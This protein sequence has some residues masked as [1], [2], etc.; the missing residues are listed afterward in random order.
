MFGRVIRY[1]LYGSV[2]VGSGAIVYS[3]D[4]AITR[5]SRAAITAIDIGRTYKSMLYSKEWDKTSKEYIELK[6]QAHQIGAEKL[7]K[8]C[9][10]NKGVYIKVGQHIGALDYL[11]PSEYVM[12]MRVLHKDAPQNTLDELYKVI[13]EDLKKD[14]EELFDEFETEPLGTA[15]LAQVHKAKLKDGT[16]V[17]VKVQHF[18]LDK[19]I[20]TDMKCMEVIINVMSKV[21]PE[22]QMQW[23]VDETKKNIQKEIDFIQEGQNAERVADMFKNYSWLKVPKIYWDY[24]TKRVLVMEYCHGGQVNDIEYVKNHKI[25]PFDLCRKIGD[26]FS[27]MIFVE[28]FLHSDP[29][30]GNIL[31]RKEPGDKHVTVTLLDHGLY[32]NL[33]EKFRYHYSKLWLSIISRDKEEMS[34]HAEQLGI[35]KELYILFACMVTG[36]PWE[37]ILKGIDRTKPTSSEK[38]QFQ[39]ELPHFL[40]YVT[41]CLETVDRQA[42]LVLKTNDL[43]RSIEHALGTR[44]HMV[45]FQVM[46]KCCMKSIYNLE[47]KQQNSLWRRWLLSVNYTMSIFMLYIYG[48][49]LGIVKTVQE[50]SNETTKPTFQ[51]DAKGRVIL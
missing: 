46:S 20:K 34:V 50:K 51:T 2:A 16:E 36:R 41:E 37:S 30:P 24:S 11:L 33:T 21:F 6:K 19:T 3:D 9:K 4:I 47:Y 35:R 8:L 25:E 23:L 10:T 45:G 44:E 13:R 18:F 12:T 17:A 27:H 42:L 1:G 29:H 49:Y 7:L 32:A 14:P 38:S 15:S 39:D 43:I 40:H 26:L 31:V 48:V 22:F 28:G 5:V